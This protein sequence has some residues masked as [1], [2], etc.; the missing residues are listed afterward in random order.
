MEDVVLNVAPLVWRISRRCH[1][2]KRQ[3]LGLG[4]EAGEAY[5][6]V[7]NAGGRCVYRGSLSKINS[8]IP[9]DT[10]PTAIIAEQTG[11]PPN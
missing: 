4:D 2:W 6:E 5:A 9:I 3:G 7:H 1:E 11:S 10:S 8:D